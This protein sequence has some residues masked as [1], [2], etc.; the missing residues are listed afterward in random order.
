MAIVPNELLSVPI[1]DWISAALV[2]TLHKLKILA[3]S[4]YD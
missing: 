3:I 4:A 1:R 2:G